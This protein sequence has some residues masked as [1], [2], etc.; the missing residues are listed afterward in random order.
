MEKLNITNIQKAI[1]YTWLYADFSDVI[2]K[3]LPIANQ[4]RIAIVN[5]TL[6]NGPTTPS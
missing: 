5:Q 1:L 4:P 3:F 2:V 6:T